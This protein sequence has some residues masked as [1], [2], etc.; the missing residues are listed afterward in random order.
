MCFGCNSLYRYQTTSC[1]DAVL[2]VRIVYTTVGAAS[3]LFG[4]WF[5]PHICC[6][7]GYCPS[8]VNAI[9]SEMRLW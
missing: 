6:P 9:D 7:A 3:M 5:P 4:Q 8:F 1:V 2:V